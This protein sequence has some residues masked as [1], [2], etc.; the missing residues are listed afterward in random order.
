ME[1]ARNIRK[2]SS[3]WPEQLRLLGWR[4]APS[5]QRRPV[6]SRCLQHAGGPVQRS[7]GSGAA[8][9][10][11]QPSPELHN[12]HPEVL[13]SISSTLVLYHACQMT[14]SAKRRRR[15]LSKTL[16]ATRTRRRA[17]RC[18]WGSR[19]DSLDGW[20]PVCS[21]RSA[22][23]SSTRSLEDHERLVLRIAPEPKLLGAY[24]NAHNRR[25]HP[26]F[27]T[28][29]FQGHIEAAYRHMWQLWQNGETTRLAELQSR[30]ASDRH[31]GNGRCVE[32]L[33]RAPHCKK[34]VTKVW[35]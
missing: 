21:T 5:P 35:R 32:D 26:L 22:F 24:R 14:M 27:D 2:P 28:H 6:P 1:I 25:T 3:L 15:G 20:L 17:T 23:L 30:E 11:E 18:R 7:G 9:M 8:L 33:R 4:C 12:G 13:L 16:P 10:A 31:E 34:R 29:R 19:C